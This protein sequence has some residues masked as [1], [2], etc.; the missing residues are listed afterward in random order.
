[1]K[2]KLR[3]IK[4]VKIAHKRYSEKKEM[5]E[6]S[7]IVIDAEKQAPYPR[8]Y[9]CIFPMNRFSFSGNSKV[10]S[11]FAKIFGCGVELP[12]KL[13]QKALEEYANDSEIKEEIL[14][15]IQILSKGVKDE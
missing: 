15:R 4:R 5:N 6:V 13:L 8:N 12:L 9:V 1:M 10:K 2:P 3:I 11:N 7:F 14:N